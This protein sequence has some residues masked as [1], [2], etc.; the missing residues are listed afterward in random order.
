PATRLPGHDDGVGAQGSC[1]RRRVVEPGEE[2]NATDLPRARSG[3]GVVHESNNH[4]GRAQAAVD[5]RH[6]VV[7]VIGASDDDDA[8]EVMPEL[9]LPGQP[10][11]P[12]PPARE[13][14]EY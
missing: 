9:A 7:D 14:G 4:V 5:A 13:Q 10:P 1:R 3:R 8:G 11:A 6:D 12:G 2:W